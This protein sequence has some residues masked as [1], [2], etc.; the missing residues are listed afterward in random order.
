M[1]TDP[2]E[3]REFYRR[4]GVLQGLG[5]DYLWIDGVASERWD[6]NFPES[7]LGPDAP[8]PPQIK[9]R[10]TCP[11]A[12]DLHWDTLQNA[13]R[14]G[15]R[16]TGV[17]MCGSESLRR[18]SQMIDVVV[19]EG[20][21]TMEKV[22]EQMYS[23]EHCDMIGKLPDTIATLKKYNFMLSCG[24]DYIKAS[25]EWLRDYA[26]TTPNILDFSE[27]FNTWIKSGVNLVGQHYGGGAIAGGE[28]G[29]RQYQPPMYMLWLAVTRK[30]DGRVWNPE[31]RIDRVWAYKMWTRWAANY[32][33]RPDQLGSLEKGKAADMVVWDRD[34]F[35]VTEDDILK[36]RPLVNMIGG[37]MGVVNESIAKEWGIPEAGVQF[38]FDDAQ[39]K[40]IGDAF[41]ED[42]KKDPLTPKG[43]AR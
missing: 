19:K 8:A 21:I 10:E 2:Q 6:S 40:G 17:H 3:T 22:R 35:T 18:M 13:I 39:L 33:R 27:P 37:K 16:M 26:A 34:Y 9:S 31:E 30:H 41:T 23:L 36:V 14:Y 4:S 1:P 7:C 29:G 32:V 12:G 38:N 11:H 43:A 28:G 24:P 5:G 42:A 25:R 20:S 15:W